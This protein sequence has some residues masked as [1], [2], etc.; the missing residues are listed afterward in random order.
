VINFD[1][2]SFFGLTDVG[3]RRSH[4]QDAFTAIPAK[5]REVWR[6][7]GHFFMVADGMGGHAVG[8][9]ASQQAARDIPLA[10]QKYA[11]E[12]V[13][14]A[15]RRAFV[16]VNAAIH[17]VGVR[18]R[19]FQGM[20][21]TA[22]ALVLR[23]DGAWIAHVGDSRVYRV[24]AGRVQQLTFDHSYLWEMARRQKV[25][26]DELQGL[27]S[28]V[29]IRSLGPDSLVQVDLEGPHP[30]EPGDVFVLCSDGLSGPVTDSEIGAIASTL[31]PEEAV[32]FLIQLANLRGGPDNITALVVR[33]AE[34]PT[35]RRT[36]RSFVD[37]VRQ[38][39]WSIPGLILGIILAVVAVPAF[40]N[41]RDLGLFMFLA[42]AIAIV[43]SLSGLL[44]HARAERHRQESQ[45]EIGEPHIYRESPCEIDAL[46]V[47]KLKRSLGDLKHKVAE[48]FPKLIPEAFDTLFAQA[49]NLQNQGDLLG[50][51]RQYCRAMH[52]LARSYNSIH[53]KSEMFQPVW[54]KKKK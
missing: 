22:T 26:P 37:F 40:L 5:S 1:A 25:N 43:F 44:I 27:K 49:E 48:S 2:V 7:Q 18:N 3:I 13:A 19:E 46:V 38:V 50:A 8:E 54:E 28:N 29:I 9:K 21:T 30:L 11:K 17:A 33:V 45:T 39:H 52:D 34:A 53:S 42:A 32:R 31:S 36:Q 15:L 20:G 24:R 6:A 10:Y 51:F 23:P 16:E 14:Q 35:S 41:S 12:G 47:D 4:N